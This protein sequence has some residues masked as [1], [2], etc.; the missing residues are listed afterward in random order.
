[1]ESKDL[2]CIAH[3]VCACVYKTALCKQHTAFSDT[4]LQ[5]MAL[6]P[7]TDNQ[8]NAATYITIVAVG[9]FTKKYH[10]ITLSIFFKSLQFWMKYQ[11][12]EGRIS[13]L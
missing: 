11:S 1:M 3:H 12:N 9:K 2:Y 8:W 7:A 13:I 10:I 6:T 5:L 4:L